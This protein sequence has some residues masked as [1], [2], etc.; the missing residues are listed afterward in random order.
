MCA[1][2]GEQVTLGH[3]IEADEPDSNKNL[4]SNTC[5][6]RDALGNLLQIVRSGTPS[7]TRTYAYDT[8]SRLTSV[9][10]PERA[11]PS[12]TACAV[13]YGYDNNS[14]LQTRTAP[15]PNANT[16]CT[17]TVTSTY[18]HDSL[19]RLTKITYSDGSTPTVQ[20]AYDG[21]TLSGC[22][23]APPTLS[24]SNKFGRMTAMCDG[25]G[26][27]SWA[28]D[29]SGGII[30][31]MRIILGSPALTTSY[32]YNLDG[33][34]ATVTYPS[35]KVVT[36]TVG[37]AQRL[38]AAKDVSN[39]I[40]FA[41]AASYAAPGMLQ[42]LVT[43]QI[44]GGFGGVTESHIYNTSLEYTST[45]A[46]PPSP[47]SASLDLTLQYTL[48]GGDNGTVTNILNNADHGR[49]QTLTYD[50]LNRI[51]SA[52]SSATSGADCWGQ[53]FGPDGTVADDA[54]ANLTKINNGT[55]T[56]PPCTIGSLN[57]TVDANNRINT[58]STYAYDP[59]GNMTKDGSGTGWL[60]TFD[61][62]N[63]LT[64]AAGPTGGP[65]CY[66]Y[67]GL[68][69]RVAK[70][71]NATTC[72]S[73]TVSK[74]YWR[75]L[76]GDAL[77][78]TDGTGSV[79]A[80]Y[81]DYVFFAGRRVAS[82]VTGSNSAN[83]AIFYYF[84]DQL[85]STRTITTGSGKNNDGSSQT[86]GQLCWDQDYTPYGQEVFTT[87]NMT[88]LQTTACPP[89][90]K[91]TGYE[92]DSE[93]GLDYAFARYY[94]S[95]L[96]RFLSTDPLG[97]SVGS[98]QSNNA[99][100]YVVNNPMNLTD[101]SGMHCLPSG[102]LGPGAGACPDSDGPCEPECGGG[103]GRGPGCG[104]DCL[105]GAGFAG[106]LGGGYAGACPAEFQSCVP[107]GSGTFI[108]IEGN[109]IGYNI[110]TDC[111][112]LHSI[113]INTED[114]G[115]ETLFLFLP[116]VGGAGSSSADFL[117]KLYANF[118]VILNNCI[119]DVFGIHAPDVPYQSEDN[120]PTLNTSKTSG[121]L[122]GMCEYEGNIAVGCHSTDPP[123]NGTVFISS[124]AFNATG[125]NAFMNNSSSFV[126]ELGNLLDEHLYSA[127]SKPDSP[128]YGR[129]F[130]NTS[131]NDQDTGANLADCFDKAAKAAQK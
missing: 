1:E 78:E 105:S 71:S 116:G 47:S 26:A 119:V 60:Y 118:Q 24:D 6:S 89:S 45:K 88:R 55:Q 22:G 59:A 32:S 127:T 13:T 12:G 30:T 21:N 4:T 11:N 14:N 69:L 85:G 125:P 90:Y 46:Q 72:S 34:I 2:N 114:C 122:A 110:A 64:L 77:T 51:L 101:P 130:P 15:A 80:N 3:T 107:N 81:T 40:Q 44:S 68:G 38:T 79:T 31:E 73:G 117:K 23:T 56:P 25:S 53:N 96:G 126:H 91:F 100:A 102:H 41:T 5:Y 66:V 29:A 112:Y 120:A 61:A 123:P 115:F 131:L 128:F 48:T 75:S 83:T 109:G 86:P 10:I 106:T 17:T 121:E 113:D 36:Y 39:S 97:G 19:N 52:R 8:L 18:Y 37:N 54:V 87:A 9:T 67:D 103:G 57:A 94:S 70:K 93:T 98:L 95:R 124:Q 43:G 84:A 104:L 62:E 42:G 49:D 50:P 27:T 16:S 99:Y 92:R 28:H 65:Y 33:S 111:G 108:G 76:S 58:D 63:R 129:H 20:Y 82:R 35:G 7:Q 74:L